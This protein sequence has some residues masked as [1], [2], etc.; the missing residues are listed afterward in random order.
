MK[1]RLGP[2]LQFGLHRVASLGPFGADLREGEIAFGEL[3]AATVDPVEDIDHDIQRLVGTRHFLDVK[4]DVS[5]AKKTAETRHVVA[6][7]GDVDG[8]GAQAGNK[9]S[10]SGGALLH[11]FRHIDP[12]RIVLHL[13]RLV[14]LEALR[15]QVEAEAGEGLRVAVEKLRWSSANDSVE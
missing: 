3:G 4:V 2:V 15:F 13:H 12:K 11:Q 10:E 5:D 6:N 8:I 1:V 14:E 9:L 7:A